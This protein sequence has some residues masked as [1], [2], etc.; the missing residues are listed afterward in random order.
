M[1]PVLGL[2]SFVKHAEKAKGR[3][4]QTDSVVAKGEKAHLISDQFSFT[5]GA[6]VDKKGNVFFTDQPNN[7]IWKYST[8]GKLSV[9]LENAHRANGMYFDKKGNLIVCADEVDELLKISK[10]GKITVLVKDFGGK[11]LNGPNDAWVRPDGGI[12]FSDPYYARAYW[13]RKKPDLDGEK[14]YFMATETSTPIIVE[15]KLRQPNGIVGTKDG[16]YL[17]VADFKG[18]KTY[19]YVINADGTLSDKTLAINQGSDGMTLDEKGNI[20][21]CGTGGVTVF[22]PEGKKIDHIAIPESWTANLCF[23][24]K[25]RDI[26]FITASKSLY[27]VKMNVK[28]IE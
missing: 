9:F 23:G 19:K 18:N 12:Y 17:Y 10:D 4:I 16:K 2:L 27:M 26:L 20:Y 28:G 6:S 7:K 25:K 24:G 22:N 1:L 11:R 21:M 5:E 13:D 14:V 15:D 3:L 8:D